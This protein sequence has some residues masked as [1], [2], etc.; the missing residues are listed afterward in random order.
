M[1]GES[2][3]EVLREAEG[4]FGGGEGGRCVGFT[5]EGPRR[6]AFAFVTVAHA[7]VYVRAVVF[8]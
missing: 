1:L 3:E 8:T 5:E 6:Y 2:G 4:F 7:H